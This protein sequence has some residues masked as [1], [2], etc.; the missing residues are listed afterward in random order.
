MENE[1]A[2]LT[3]RYNNYEMSTQEYYDALSQLH[4]E[5]EIQQKED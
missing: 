2:I 3:D 5:D 1:E 4:S